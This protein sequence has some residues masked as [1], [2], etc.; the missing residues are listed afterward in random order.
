MTFVCR[1]A[2]PRRSIR[3]CHR[4]CRACTQCTSRSSWRWTSS[5]QPGRRPT[6]DWSVLETPS[7]DG[8]IGNGIR[9]IH[10]SCT[11][12]VCAYWMAFNKGFRFSKRQPPPPPPSMLEQMFVCVPVT[13]FLWY[14]YLPTYVRTYVCTH[15]LYCTYEHMYVLY[16][17]IS[18]IV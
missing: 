1:R 14:S 8:K 7:K 3:W 9:G 4:Y 10:G 12:F 5:R 15:V 17:H 2:R 16:V 11:L 13:P 6:S 18:C